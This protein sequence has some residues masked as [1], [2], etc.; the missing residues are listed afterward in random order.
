[1]DKKTDH[2]RI[3]EIHSVLLG[4]NG[5]GGLCR[6]VEKNTKAIFRLWIFV[7][8]LS[9]SVGGGAFGIVQAVMALAG[10]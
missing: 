1:M 9:I 5:Q 4:A 8:V 2:D 10:S 7:I 6:Q 3:V